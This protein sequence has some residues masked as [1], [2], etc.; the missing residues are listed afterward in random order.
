V[1]SS[2]SAF[3]YTVTGT[4]NWTDAQG[5]LHPAR[6]VVVNL[7]NAGGTATDAT[8]MTDLSGNYTLA[9]TSI[10][11]FGF[12]ENLRIQAKN[13]GAYVSPDAT[14]DN[15][16]AA[17]PQSFTVATGTNTISV[18]MQK[19]DTFASPSFS[20]LDA[21]ETGY[22]YATLVR[23]AAPAVLPALF[24][25]TTKDGTSFFSPD[26]SNIQILLADKW[27]WDVSLHEYGHYLQNLDA[28]ADSPGTSH[29]FGVTN[30]FGP[31]KAL[32]DGMGGTTNIPWGKDQGAR[33]AWGE[34]AATYIGLAA[35]ATN[36][37]AFKTPTTM[38]N[39]GDSHYQDTD[40]STLD[41]DLAV[42]QP[43]DQQGEGDELAVS[44][45][46]WQVAT[47]PRVNRGHVKLY[48]DMVGAAAAQAGKKLQN[49]SQYNNYYLNT[50]AK[51]D[52]QRVDFG[53]VFED[54]GVSPQPLSLSQGAITGPT[55]KT[56]AIDGAFT[57][58]SAA[59]GDPTFNWL[60]GNFTANNSF[61]LYIWDSVGLT[62]RLID[63][64][65]IPGNVNTYTLTDAQWAI[66]DATP[67]MDY[68]ALTG[69]DTAAPATGPYWTDAFA[70]QVTAAPE[71]GSLA[72]MG[73]GVVML[74][75]RRKVLVT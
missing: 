2:A 68:F 5:V 46:L 60:P 9:F 39:V 57:T 67:G 50:V 43:G 52:R 1:A 40:D 31:T 23:G 16:Y 51:T 48:A 24:P 14:P 32:P 61:H 66:V 13:D 28:I 18:N 55:V 4:I 22:Q 30:I 53:S 35:E 3:T 58:I 17:F 41:I 64:F 75:R 37:A 26:D 15:V 12:T 65:L 56:V 70:F 72:M 10:S 25:N 62:N 6:D 11:P 45:I 29:N 73:A 63:N 8:G 20:V 44:R 27:D 38:A 19:T 33:L 42:A 59:G 54:N 69:G 7:L 34:G 21:L 36:V 47:G 74:A 71:P 49:L